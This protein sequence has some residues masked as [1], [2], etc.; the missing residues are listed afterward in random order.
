MRLPADGETHGPLRW[1][2]KT[3]WRAE[4][5]E[6]AWRPDQTVAR[7][8]LQ[9]RLHPRRTNYRALRPRR[10][11][12][13]APISTV[14]A[15]IESD[16]GMTKPLG[17][18]GRPPC[19]AEPVTAA[20]AEDMGPSLGPHGI[21]DRRFSGRP[22]RLL[23]AAKTTISVARTTENVGHYAGMVGPSAANLRSSQKMKYGKPGVSADVSS[24]TFDKI[25]DAMIFDRNGAN[26]IR[27]CRQA[28]CE[29][30]I[31]GTEG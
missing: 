12:P 10:F 4:A 17:F 22:H 26:I 9:R 30:R 31:T 1:L 18:I 20:Q 15:P 16:S 24:S 28:L 19:D 2:A 21:D 23:L 8:R 29:H 27:V 6:F 11:P 13:M 7:L 25:F 3:V 14:V 5:T